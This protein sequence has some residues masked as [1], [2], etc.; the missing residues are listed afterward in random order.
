MA[1]HE[2]EAGVLGKLGECD[3]VVARSG[4][5]FLD[6]D[7]LAGLECT[8]G[9]LVVSG[10]RR[11]DRDRVEA[12]ILEERLEARCLGDRAGS[13]G[14]SLERLRSSVAD[15]R[16]LRL[17]EA[18]RDSERGWVPSNRD[19]RRRFSPFHPSCRCRSLTD[20]RKRG[21]SQE[22]EVEAERPAARVRR[23]PCRAPRRSSHYARAVTCQRPVDA[24]RD[25]EAFEVMRSEVL[26]L[27]RDAGPW[28]DERH[29]SLQDV[30]ELG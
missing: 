21:S 29:V 27:V 28:A 23:R 4:E 8:A 30:D 12:P 7:V 14:L 2:H 22:T 11:R 9:E 16:R 3:R 18:R 1:R 24:R 19:R 15:V 20:D 17:R 6:E 10:D 13:G 25:E 5:G 26:G